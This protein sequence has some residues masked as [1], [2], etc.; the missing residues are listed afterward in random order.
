MN[1]HNTD[2]NFN[3]AYAFLFGM[4][5]ALMVLTLMHFFMS[6]ERKIAKVNVTAI[7]AQF[8]QQ[9]SAKHLSEVDLKSEVQL[10]GKQL[11]KNLQQMAKTN[12]LVLLPSEAVIAGVPDDTVIIQRTLKGLSDEA[13]L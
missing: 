10:F 7:V 13:I 9:E 3:A 11:E 5:G 1:I 6:P 2:F 4:L 8:I 12:H